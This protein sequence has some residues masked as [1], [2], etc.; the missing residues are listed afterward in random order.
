MALFPCI[1]LSVDNNKRKPGLSFSTSNNR[2]SPLVFAIGL[3]IL[4]VAFWVIGL[5]LLLLLSLLLGRRSNN[6]TSFAHT[7]H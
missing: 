7:C 4:C 3:L 1:L 6:F 2:F 5:L